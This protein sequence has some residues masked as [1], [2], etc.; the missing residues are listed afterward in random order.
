MNADDDTRTQPNFVGCDGVDLL[1]QNWRRFEEADHIIENDFGLITRRSEHENIADLAGGKFALNEN[2]LEDSTRCSHSAF[3]ASSTD[4]GSEFADALSR[5][6]ATASNTREGAGVL[7]VK[8]EPVSSL[9]NCA[10][11]LPLLNV[12]KRCAEQHWIERRVYGSGR[13]RHGGSS[14]SSSAGGCCCA[15]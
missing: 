13:Q 2:S 11:N 10:P 3:A 9:Q 4:D 7:P 8:G 1:L 14:S 5:W 12:V 6:P 15:W